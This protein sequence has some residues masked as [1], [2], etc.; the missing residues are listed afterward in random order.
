MAQ[1]TQKKKFP[2]ETQRKLRQHTQIKFPQQ[3][4]GV[5]QKIKSE[6]E[7][8]KITE[9]KN[10]VF[11]YTLILYHC[12]FRETQCPYSKYLFQYPMCKSPFF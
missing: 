5:S 9:M 2:H 4:Q 7:K 6:L 10:Y 12:Y 1:K 8:R 11:D 3:I